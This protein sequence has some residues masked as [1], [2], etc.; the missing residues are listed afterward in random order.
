MK[1]LHSKKLSAQLLVTFSA[2]SIVLALSGIIA[3]YTISQNMDNAVK[4]VNRMDIKVS[5]PER[6][7]LLIHDA[8]GDFK[9]SLLSSDNSQY[10]TYHQKL[11]LA[12]SEID[13]LLHINADTTLLYAEQYV[14]LKHWYD[15]KLRLTDRLYVLKKVIDSFMMVDS[16]MNRSLAENTIGRAADAHPQKFVTKRV[17]TLS[18]NN[19]QKRKKLFGRLKDAI[20]NNAPHAS[21]TYVQIYEKTAEDSTSIVNGI[22]VAYAQG[23]FQRTM[24][25]MRQRNADLKKVQL[26]L[27][28]LERHINHQLEEIINELDAANR[29]IANTVKN[30]ALRNYK[31]TLRIVNNFCIAALLFVLAFASLLII[32]LRKF[33]RSEM[34]LQ[35]ENDRAVSLAR[36]KMDL[37]YHLSH[38]IRNPVSNIRGFLHIFKLSELSPKQAELL[39]SI[40]LST[41]LLLNTV[42]DVLSAARLENSEFTL[43]WKTFHP[44]KTLRETIN[45]MRLT[46]DRKNITLDLE[47]SGSASTTVAGDALR[48]EQIMVNLLSNA[49]KFTDKGGVRVKADL[50]N[51]NGKQEL[52]VSVADTGVGMTPDEQEK[53]FSKYYRTSSS[54]GKTGTG[55]GLYICKQFIEL[56]GGTIGVESMPG[57]GSTFH[58]NIRYDEVNTT[59]NNTKASATELEQLSILVV[60]DNQLSLK[61]FKLMMSRTHAKLL[62]AENG[63]KALSI[64]RSEKVSV[65]FTDIHMPEMDGFELL[66]AIKKLP[67][68]LNKIPVIAMNGDQNKFDEKTLIQQG[69]SAVGNKPILEDSVVQLISAVLG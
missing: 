57:K 36:Q 50:K 3:R 7:L 67:V 28:A 64:L 47:Y 19:S 4:E 32:Y 66:A 27:V 2:F 23:W 48:L 44:E 42:N 33:T 20:L 15:K 12:F 30:A 51:L 25:Q 56:Q 1:I 63:I 10:I 52:S 9:T 53:L 31:D 22:P 40:D 14:D 37:L 60:D 18:A 38:E 41:N 43:A 68:P 24:E 17:D 65:I 49:I 35:T 62:F 34:M 55:L 6:I 54:S 8:E 61:F 5:K 39:S 69:F 58:F 26:S 11:M 45:S 13:T 29:A 46:A 16:G 21:E 59:E